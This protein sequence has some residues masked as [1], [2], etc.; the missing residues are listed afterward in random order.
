MKTNIVIDYFTINPIFSKFISLELWAKI[1]LAN[2][3]TG[4][5]EMQYLKKEVNDEVYFWHTDKYQS[6]LQVDTIILYVC[7]QESPK[8]PK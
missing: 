6:F 2:Q 8:Y 7:N 4:F 1:L 5:L 3:I